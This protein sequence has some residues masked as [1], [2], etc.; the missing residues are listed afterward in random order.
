LRMALI[1]NEARLRQAVRQIGRC[2]TT[3]DPRPVD[4]QEHRVRQESNVEG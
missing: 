4:G 2:L 1:E 3:A